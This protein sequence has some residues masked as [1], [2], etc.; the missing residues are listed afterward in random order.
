MKN[1]GLKYTNKKNKI[2]N[3]TQL[4]TNGIKWRPNEN[5]KQ[6]GPNKGI[7]GETRAMKAHVEQH[8]TQD[9][10][11]VSHLDVMSYNFLYD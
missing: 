8:K 2:I 1:T 11:Q 3:E 10:T 6:E 4:E 5:R 7:E 9:R